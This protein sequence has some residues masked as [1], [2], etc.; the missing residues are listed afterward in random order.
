MKNKQNLDN[1]ALQGA[2]S[3]RDRRISAERES[4]LIDHKA[5][6]LEMQSLKED[7]KR[8][9]KKK[10]WQL[11]SHGI[12]AMAISTGLYIGFVRPY[13][14]SLEKKS[15]HAEKIILT[16][17][18]L[19]LSY[20][21]IANDKAKK[22]NETIAYLTKRDSAGALKSYRTLC[23]NPNNSVLREGLTGAIL[24]YDPSMSKESLDRKT[25][26]EV[27]RI[28][29]DKSIGMFRHLKESQKGN[30]AVMT[31]LIYSTALL[32]SANDRQKEDY[33]Q[34]YLGGKFK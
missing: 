21:A 17:Q 1:L 18:M 7:N 22:R 14:R 6:E 8:N 4:G 31:G 13:M 33:S 30:N 23:A 26:C 20:G 12:M 16:D 10:F 9:L 11:V 3:I 5:S 2:E 15:E 29:Y 19:D 25:S 34:K 28:F 32:K 24:T 27:G